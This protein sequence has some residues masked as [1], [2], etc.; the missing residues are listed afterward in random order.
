MPLEYY[1]SEWM[2]VY[3][4]VTSVY[5]F[6]VYC[7]CFVLFVY[8]CKGCALYYEDLTHNLVSISKFPRHLSSSIIKKYRVVYCDIYNVVR[9]TGNTFSV[10]MLLYFSFFLLV[11][12]KSLFALV[13]G[14]ME[15]D[16]SF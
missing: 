7:H 1:S 3:L 14:L 11:F 16:K 12:T 4:T 15:N 6:C 5:M 13:V 8:C 2:N 10:Q 9:L